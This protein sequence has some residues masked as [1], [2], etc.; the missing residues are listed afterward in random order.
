[1]F[2]LIRHGEPDY[3]EANTKIHGMLM[4]AVTGMHHPKYGEIF[5]LEI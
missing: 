3:S 4:E 1:M 2:Y 5:E